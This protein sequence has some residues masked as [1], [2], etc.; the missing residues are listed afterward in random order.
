MRRGEREMSETWQPNPQQQRAIDHVHGPLRIVAGAGTGKTGTLTQKIV[1]L[2]R[3]GH[4]RPAEILALTFTD[5][6]AAELR[7]RVD[8]SVAQLKTGS[9]R[10][11]VQTYNAF[12]GR[13]VAEQGHLLDLP[14]E[15]AL[16]TTSEAWILLWRSIAEVDFRFIELGQLKSNGFGQGEISKMLRLNGRLSDELKTVA[17]LREYLESAQL[18]DE[19]EQLGDYARALQVYEQKKREHGAIDFGDQVAMAARLLQRPDVAATYHQRYRFVLVDEFQDTNYAQAVMVR[20]LAPDANGNV[21]V[22]GDPNQAIYLFRGAAPDNLERFVTDD[23]PS[24]V[25]IPLSLNYRSTQLVLDA[26]N[27]LWQEDRAHLQDQL[28]SADGKPGIKPVLVTALTLED[29]K[30]WVAG[31]ILR[32]VERGEVQFREI[33]V[34]ARSNALKLEFWKALDQAGIPAIAIGGDSLLAMPEVREVISWL[35][36]IANRDD[37]AA[38]LHIMLTDRWGLDEQDIYGLDV[39][40]QRDESLAA[41]VQRLLA[42]GA[43]PS[44]AGDFLAELDRLTAISYQVSLERLVD[45]IVKVRRGAYTATEQRNL[46]QFGRVVEQFASARFERPAL[47]DLVEYLDLLNDAGGDDLDVDLAEEDPEQCVQV[48][49][50]HK[51]KGLEERVVFVVAAHAGSSGALKDVLPLELAHPA[52]GRP[53]RDGFPPGSNGDEAFRQVIALWQEAAGKAEARRVFYVALTRAQ[54]RLY[55]SWSMKPRGTQSKHLPDYAEP[56]IEFCNAVDAP[57]AVVVEAGAQLSSI[58]TPIL[59]NGGLKFEGEDAASAIR[60]VFEAGWIAAGGTAGTLE[61]AIVYFV[62]ER[63]QLREELEIV[64]AIERRR[65]ERA[66]EGIDAASNAFS[67]TALAC[68]LECPHRYYLRYVTGLPGRPRHQAAVIGSRFHAIVQREAERRRAGL[69]P[70]AAEVWREQLAASGEG[71]TGAGEHDPTQVDMV[72]SYL[73]SLDARAEPLLIE[74]EFS[75]RA[76]DAWIH[77]VIDRLHRLPDGAIEV[78]D[79]KTDRVARSQDEVKQGLQLP[80]YLLAMREAFPEYTPAPLKAAMFFVRLGERV[81]VEYSEDELL[82]FRQRLADLAGEVQRVD[83]RMHNASVD[84]CRWCEYNEICRFA[85]VG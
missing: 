23:F 71:A 8:E 20:A 44:G 15:P 33:A 47:A 34:L 24:A 59:L 66:A 39:A 43:V 62:R 36:A 63:E 49:T 83:P 52:A 32:L 51:A 31:E 79:Y 6:A 30:A 72:A 2:V 10:V 70:E 21:C 61:A 80:I 35:N 46:R 7:K 37:N 5:K 22:V 68:Y 84:A 77:G 74:Q 14:P 82:A 41:R 3:D 45:E 17:D 73:E 12:G 50:A 55:I 18:S 75:L 69:P 28:R 1:A 9:E 48:M 60:E 64:Q 56:V 54:E 81:E 78:V 13:V 25:S 19:T 29:E 85:V 58:A 57:V 16:L 65:I 27:A 26:A 4:A 11:Q 40:L 67:Y 38:F 76:G 42:A 53:G